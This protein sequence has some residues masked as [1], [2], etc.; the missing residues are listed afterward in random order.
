MK[1]NQGEFVGFYENGKLVNGVLKTFG[2][3][4]CIV[5]LDDNTEC[6]VPYSALRFTGKFKK[7]TAVAAVPADDAPADDAPADDAPVA[8]EPK[9]R[10]RK[11]V[12]D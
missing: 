3:R 12:E 1:H 7:K 8:D 10:G 11:K 2:V 5:V 4:E 9:K 6:A